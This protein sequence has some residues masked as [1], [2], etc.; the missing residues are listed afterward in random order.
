MSKKRPRPFHP[1]LRNAA[2]AIRHQEILFRMCTHVQNSRRRDGSAELVPATSTPITNRGH[3]SRRRQIMTNSALLCALLGAAC[4][5]AA[6]NANPRLVTPQAMP[7]IAIIDERFLSYNVEMAEVI[8]GNFWK[9]YTPEAITAM[10]AQGRSANSLSTSASPDVV[11]LSPT[12]FQARSPIESFK[13][14]LARTRGGARANLY[15]HEWNL[16]EYGLFPRFQ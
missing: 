7:S 8:G 12:M 10:R 2:N 6:A 14:S 11:G 9:P 13:P 16:G 15:A 3:V 1:L 4:P 5:A